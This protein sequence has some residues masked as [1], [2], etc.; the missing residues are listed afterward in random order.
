MIT[1]HNDIQ[2]SPPKELKTPTQQ[3]PIAI[4]KTHIL[5][6]IYTDTDLL[7][8]LTNTVLHT[9]KYFICIFDVSVCVY[10]C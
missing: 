9:Y 1:R 3:K 5:L 10:V 8:T 4:V 6:Y 7:N 2:L